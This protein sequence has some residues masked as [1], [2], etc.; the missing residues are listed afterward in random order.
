MRIWSDMKDPLFVIICLNCVQVRSAKYHLV[1]QT[2]RNVESRVYCVAFL[3]FL[4][5]QLRFV[6]FVLVLMVLSAWYSSMS[7]VYNA[8]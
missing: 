3:V 5:A 6:W 7:S 2:H 8:P 1:H 4:Y